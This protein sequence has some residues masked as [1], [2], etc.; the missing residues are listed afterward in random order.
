GILAIE[1]LVTRLPLVLHEYEWSRTDRFHNLLEGIGQRLLLAHDETWLY[2]IGEYIEKRTERLLE[3]ELKAPLT[4]DGQGGC[5]LEHRHPADIALAPTVERSDHVLGGDRRSVV[6]L[7]ARA[8]RKAVLQAVRRGGERFH[9]LRLWL[10]FGV[11][12]EQRVIDHVA[13]IERDPG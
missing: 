7:H 3:G 1:N 10:Q 12:R 13:V 4:G 11:R 9:H 6:E 8:E 2:R 5:P